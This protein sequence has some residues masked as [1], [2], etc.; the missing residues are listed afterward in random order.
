VLGHLLGHAINRHRD[1]QQRW[2]A[3]AYSDLTGMAWSYNHRSARAAENAALA[4]LQGSHPRLWACGAE[5]TIA[6]ARGPRGAFAC[7]WADPRIPTQACTVAL[8]RCQATYPPDDPDRH[9]VWLALVLDARHG[10]MYQH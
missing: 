4:H 6:V 9:Q 10:V 2:C 3:I 7:H 1:A 8:A 5:I